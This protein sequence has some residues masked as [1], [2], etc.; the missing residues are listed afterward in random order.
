MSTEDVVKQ[1]REIADGID[2]GKLIPIEIH[3]YTDLRQQTVDLEI[4]FY[5]AP[6]SEEAN[7]D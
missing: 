6:G 3:N 1:L 5:S 7:D 4:H 2:S